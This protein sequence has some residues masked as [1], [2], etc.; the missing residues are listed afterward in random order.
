MIVAVKALVITRIYQLQRADPHS[1]C[2]EGCLQDDILSSSAGGLYWPLNRGKEENQRCVRKL[3]LGS[4]T[5]S[6][7]NKQISDVVVAVAV[8]VVSILFTNVLKEV[9]KS[10]KREDK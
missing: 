5:T 3:F 9:F 7:D 6:D 1:V 4:K 8:V 10:L 2:G